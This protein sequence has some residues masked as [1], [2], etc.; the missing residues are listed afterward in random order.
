MDNLLPLYMRWVGDVEA[1]ERWLRWSFISTIS[2]MLTNRV[3]IMWRTGSQEIPVYPNLYTLLLGPS[4]DGKSFSIGRSLSLLEQTSYKERLVLFHGKITAPGL[5]DEMIRTKR[6]PV[7]DKVFLVF[8]EMAND[9]GMREMSDMLMKSLTELYYGQEFSER[10]RSGFKVHLPVGYCINLLAG[11]TPRW[12]SESVTLATVEG[13]FFPRTNCIIERPEG[14][15]LVFEYKPTKDHNDIE[16]YLVTRMEKILG[17]KGEFVRS[18]EALELER[19]WYYSRPKPE[20]G[21]DRAY[22]RQQHAKVMKFVIT[23]AVLDNSYFRVTAKHMQTAIDWVNDASETP[24]EI[25]LKARMTKVS[26]EIEAVNDV[27][28]ALR[29]RGRA[30][31]TELL[32]W[33]GKRGVLADKL[34]RWIRHWIGQGDVEEYRE[35]TQGRPTIIYKF[36]NPLRRPKNAKTDKRQGAGKNRT[37]RGNDRGGTVDSRDDAGPDE[38]AS[39]NSGSGGTKGGE[40]ESGGSGGDWELVGSED[41]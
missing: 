29:L 16:E 37:A 40:G 8:D 25:L 2:A 31:R 6:H 21:V 36:V 34:D 35:K 5:Y 30:T 33:A 22:F 15:K 32:R 11:S 17:L 14:V 18:K 27:F 12:L 38:A 3:W 19:D 41:W 20:P 39:G 1:P 28:E 7:N 10:T 9:V 23:A 13:G 26:P 4:G 24:E